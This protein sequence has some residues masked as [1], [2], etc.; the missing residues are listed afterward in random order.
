MCICLLYALT[1]ERGALKKSTEKL[2]DYGKRI[3]EKDAHIEQVMQEGERFAI[4]MKLPGAP[5]L[6]LT[7]FVA[8][9]MLTPTPTPQVMEEGERLA[10]KQADMEGQMKKLRQQMNALEAEKKKLQTN[11]T[12]EQSESETLRKARAKMERDLAAAHEHSKAELESQKHHMDQMLTKAK[13]DQLDAEERGGWKLRS[14]VERWQVKAW[15]VSVVRLDAEERGREVAS[16]GLARKLRESESRCEA[17]TES[18]VEF[19]EALDRQRQAADLREEMLKQDISD[20]ERRCHA[21]ELRHQEL[22]SKLPEAT[23]PLLRQIEAMQA[24]TEAQGKAASEAQGEAWEGAERTLTNRINEAESRA[25]SAV[26]RERLTTERTQTLHNKVSA[27][28]A[29]LQA[30]RGEARR[31]GDELMECERRLD[32]QEESRRM[33]QQQ[34]EGLVEKNRILQLQAEHAAQTSAEA[35][36]VARNARQAAEADALHAAQTSAEALA[37]E[38]DARQAAEA[39]ALHVQKQCEERIADIEAEIHSLRSTGGYRSQSFK[40]GSTDGGGVGDPPAMAAPGYHWVLVRDGELHQQQ[41]QPHRGATSTTGQDGAGE[42]MSSGK[43]AARAEASSETVDTVGGLKVSELSQSNGAL[44]S[45]A[46]DLRQALRISHGEMSSMEGR[47]HELQASRDRGG[48]PETGLAYGLG[49]R[50]ASMSSKR[51]GTGRGGG[52]KTGLAYG[53]GWRDASMS[54]KRFGTVNSVLASET[55]A[56]DLR[57]ALRISHGE[58]SSMEGR[59]HELQASRDRLA[60][61]LVMMAQRSEQAQ[62]VIYEMENLKSEVVDT[63]GRYIAAVELL[64]ERDESLEELRAD[65]MEVKLMYKDQIEFMCVQLAQLQAARYPNGVPPSDSRMPQPDS[66]GDQIHA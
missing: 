49:W 51:L 21:T 33:G 8:T 63:R 62:D 11:L 42:A 15:P 61:E 37:V 60:E 1:N 48:G 41:T 47:I 30:A 59:I 9:P 24:A 40:Q 52:P 20:L 29:A 57:Q 25:A 17:L 6:D 16:Q 35:L 26:E 39:D 65:L 27:L 43:A 32:A 28:E 7:A 10:S 66:P 13:A 53:L 45:E 14:E 3:R 2:T 23:R 36:A 4:N 55:E 46:E 34:I 12:T 56:E 22:T 50:D 31:L 54:S 38:R 58:M 64:G 18:V 44:A 19:R 5:M